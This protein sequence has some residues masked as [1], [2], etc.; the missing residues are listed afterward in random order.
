MQD[1]SI[2]STHISIYFVSFSPM[3]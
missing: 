1:G 3:R 2:L